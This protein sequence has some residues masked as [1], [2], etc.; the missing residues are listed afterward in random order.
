MFAGIC[1]N[2]SSSGG[3]GRVDLKPRKS[4]EV[5]GVR[6]LEVAVSTVC[7]ESSGGMEVVV[8]ER[9]GWEILG[10]ENECLLLN[11]SLDFNLSIS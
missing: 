2:A 6:E 3:V 5:Q 11:S 4:L 8:R 1:F 9:G 7:V 10:P